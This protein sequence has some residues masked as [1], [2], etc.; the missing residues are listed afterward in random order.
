MEKQK[1]TTGRLL[2]RTKIRAEKAKLIFGFPT[3]ESA[4]NT[5]ILLGIKAYREQL[6]EIKNG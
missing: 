6:R 3:I 2:K 1:F 4:I 5:F